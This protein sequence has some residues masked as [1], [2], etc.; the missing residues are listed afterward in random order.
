MSELLSA[1]RE[2]YLDTPGT[3]FGLWILLTLG[4]YIGAAL[5]ARRKARR[6]D[7]EVRQDWS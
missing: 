6:K 3:G 7:R 5:H 4:F 1:F 2:W